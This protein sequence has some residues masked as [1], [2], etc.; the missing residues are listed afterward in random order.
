ML[1]TPLHTDRL[2]HRSK[3]EVFIGLRKITSENIDFDSYER[4][5]ERKQDAINTRKKYNDNIKKHCT[6]CSV[7]ETC[8]TTFR[9]KK[10][11]CASPYPPNE[12][13]DKY[14]LK[15]DT[16]QISKDT[17]VDILMASGSHSVINTETGRRC[18]AYIS[19]HNNM[20]GLGF[21]V[22]ARASGR[23]KILTSG[24]TDKEWIY[25]KVQNNINTNYSEFAR[26]ELHERLK[27]TTWY[28]KLLAC[29][30]IKQSPTRVSMFH[31][32]AYPKAYLETT[33]KSFNVKFLWTSNRKLCPWNYEVKDWED[34]FGHYGRIPGFR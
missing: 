22:I 30:A 2:H 27:D 8:H 32:T 7:K 4:H 28:A 33:Y 9:D 6:V 20:Y 10:K 12:E 31:S 17:I 11:Y 29:A 25:F 15:D 14:F 24:T 26:N 1:Y 23:G 3:A 21:R 13:I 18:D 34:L 16:T 5:L 19:L